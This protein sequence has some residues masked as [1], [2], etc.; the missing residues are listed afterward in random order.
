[1]NK[2]QY[3]YTIVTAWYDVREKENHPLKDKGSNDYFCSMD[4]Y[5][6]SAKQLFNKPFPMVI[7]TEPRFKELILSAR[8]P[9]LH[10]M[11]RF[12]FKDY[13]ELLIIHISANT[14]R[15]TTAIRL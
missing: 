12:I 2:I 7:Y 14:R 8:P 1:M 13:E 5:F 6:E 15:T 9:P 11:T 3:D 10:S 4:W